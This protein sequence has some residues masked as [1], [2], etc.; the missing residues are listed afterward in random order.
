MG[1][2]AASK[3]PTSEQGQGLWPSRPEEILFIPP[4]TF[5]CQGE[6]HLNSLSLQGLWP[7]GYTVW[8][9]E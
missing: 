4:A 6:G 3:G 7:Y 5:Q 9:G 8:Q 2:P 1:P